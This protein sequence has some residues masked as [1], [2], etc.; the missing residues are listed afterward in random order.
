MNERRADTTRAVSEDA[1]RRAR[2]LGT[3][4]SRRARRVRSLSVTVAMPVIFTISS[5]TSPERAPLNPIVG[6]AQERSLY[7]DRVEWTELDQR[8]SDMIGAATTTDAMRPALE[9]LINQLG[10]QHAT[11][12]SST[13]HSIVAS[14][15][16]P[17]AP[18]TEP[19]DSEFLREVIHDT[20]AEFESSMIGDD[21]GYLRLVGIGPGDV[22]AQTNRIREG[23]QHL[24]SSGATRWILDLRYNGGGNMNPMMAGLAP[25]FGE[26]L[27]GGAVDAEGHLVR[28]YMIENGTFSDTGRTIA[29]QEP[30][31]TVGDEVQ[32]AV[33]LSRYTISSGELVAVAMRGREN[34]RFV[35]ERTAGYTTGTGYEDVG[36]GLLMLLSESEFVDRNM[37]RYPHGVEPDVH[38]EFRPS[39]GLEEDEQIR[40]ALEW[41]RHESM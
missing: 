40:V 25:L 3:S 31:P 19:W 11:F 29:V 22:D 1:T 8:F 9:F 17:I 34:T 21:V 18:R 7:A 2:R 36:H 16:G 37:N 14:Y 33:L 12:R 24:E 6:R 41:F 35:G 5:C 32:I 13:D 27:V 20:T 10:D 15:T 38:S 4:M 28:Q 30:G 23:L 26:G 39:H